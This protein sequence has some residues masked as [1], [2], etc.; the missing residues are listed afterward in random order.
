MTVRMFVLR[1]N[2]NMEW[3]EDVGKKF[4]ILIKTVIYFIS[5]FY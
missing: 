4:I 5:F 2:K 1:N 3:K